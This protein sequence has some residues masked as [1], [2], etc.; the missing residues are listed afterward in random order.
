M[1]GAHGTMPLHRVECWRAGPKAELKP[2]NN[3]SGSA[4][5]VAWFFAVIKLK[6]GAPVTLWLDGQC[7]LQ[8]AV[9]E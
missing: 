9:A 3:N 1:T 5:D 6:R 2:R 8:W 7:A 4:P